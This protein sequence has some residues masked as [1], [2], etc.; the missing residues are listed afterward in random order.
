VQCNPPDRG[1]R[2]IKERPVM[3]QFIRHLLFDVL[4]KKTID[5]VLKLLRKLD[6]DDEEVGGFL[7][8]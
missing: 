6:W 4:S 2:Q 8:A 1:P 3:E 7:I 5:K